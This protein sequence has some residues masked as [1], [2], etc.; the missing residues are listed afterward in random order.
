VVGNGGN[1]PAVFVEAEKLGL[2]GIVSKRR[3]SHYRSG[4]TDRWRKVKCWTKSELVVVGTAVDK[5]TG[6]PTALLAE[7]AAD[8]LR[9]AGGAFITLDGR[10]R[11]RF[12]NK[13]ARLAATRP[14]L[15]GLS[16][17]YAQW[18]KPEL[19]V[20]CGISG[21]RRTTPRDRTNPS[22]LEAAMGADSA[23]QMPP[24]LALAS[25]WRR[26]REYRAEP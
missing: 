12:G 11:E 19:V 9:F 10:Q 2:E 26:A 1:G 5:K 8:G 7:D 15:P 24:G 13:L 22:K 20:G 21:G 23:P 18:V 14:P 6:A 17:R 16:A 25:G 3:D 4:L